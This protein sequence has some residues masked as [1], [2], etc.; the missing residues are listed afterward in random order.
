MLSCAAELRK[1][2][3][4]GT[5]TVLE[6]PNTLSGHSHGCLILATMHGHDMVATIYHGGGFGTLS[7]ELLFETHETFELFANIR[8]QKSDLIAA[9]LPVLELSQKK[10]CMTHN[11]YDTSP[12]NTGPS[13]P[14]SLEGWGLRITFHSR[15]SKVSPM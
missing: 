3:H 7:Q 14:E 2:Q 1:L 4:K 6:Q 8:A 11:T 15:W 10:A 9:I 5:L 12:G 13:P